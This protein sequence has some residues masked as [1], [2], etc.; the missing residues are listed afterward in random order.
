MNFGGWA[1]EK[2]EL[3]RTNAIRLTGPNGQV[4]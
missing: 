2:V 1:G 3:R 4:A